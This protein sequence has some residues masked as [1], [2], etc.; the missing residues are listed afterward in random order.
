MKIVA[1]FHD[2]KV[3]GLAGEDPRLGANPPMTMAG[4]RKGLALLP[5]ICDIGEILDG[6]D[7]C[8]SSRLARAL[9]MASVLIGELNLDLETVNELGQWANKDGDQVIYYPGHEKE[10]LCTWQRDALT[11]LDIIWRRQRQIV[12]DGGLALVVSHRPIIGGWVGHTRGITDEAG[13]VKLVRDPALTK[14]GYVVFSYDGKTLKV[15]EDWR[16]L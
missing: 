8:Y 6:F 12:A 2:D 10:N 9:D 15:V 11:A 14:K 16:D 1:V 7:A 13:L 5:E 4:M 3:E